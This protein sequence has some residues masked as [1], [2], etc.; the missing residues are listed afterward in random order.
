MQEFVSTSSDARL[1]EERRIA[2]RAEHATHGGS[3]ELL[4][5]VTDGQ[6]R[7][8]SL[9]DAQVTIGRGLENDVVLTGDARASRSHALMTSIDG[10]WKVVDRGSTNGT[11]VNSVRIANPVELN[12]GDRINIGSSAIVLTTDRTGTAA[13]R[14]G[15]L[16]AQ[17]NA[18]NFRLSVADRQLLS[19][20]ANGATDR[21]IASVMHMTV[22]E[23][24]AAVEELASRTSAPR[25]IDLARL[26]TS[27]GVG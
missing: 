10:V 4:E 8:I 25:R 13:H 15:D 26:A 7:T 27:L 5:V 9:T 3:M 20:L 1:S 19:L 24:A 16:D 12:P 6:V 17:I 18:G 14:L 21:E 11:Y 23:A 22:A 2:P